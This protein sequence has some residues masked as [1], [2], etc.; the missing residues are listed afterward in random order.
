MQGAGAHDQFESR[1][2]KEQVAFLVVKFLRLYVSFTAVGVEYRSRSAAGSL[3]GSGLFERVRAMVQ[4][5]A[6]DLKEL[7]H[8]LF[9]GGAGTYA[10]AADA[11]RRLSSMKTLIERRSI[12]SYVG[13]FFHL[14]LILQ[15]SLYQIERYT[16]ELQNEKEEIRRALALASEGGAVSSAVDRAEL[17]R[18]RTLA[19]ISAT[20][21]EESA[22]LAEQVMQRCEA[23]LHA[24]ALVIRRFGASAENNEILVLNLLQNRDLLDAVYGAGA[25]E[26]VFADLCAG[27]DVPG[28][29][30]VEKAINFVRARCGNLS[31]LEPASAS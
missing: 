2:R 7:A 23:L 15:E 13:T 4:S 16:P 8:A 24:T 25:A 14:L 26:Q 1:R 28:A 17:E 11:R 18:L 29:T 20:L 31:A 19:E 22:V 9:R 30:G 21:S 5:L 27:T 10:V 3:A 6:F 12:D